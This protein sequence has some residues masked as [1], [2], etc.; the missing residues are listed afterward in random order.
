MGKM[1]KKKIH[2]LI[3]MLTMTALILGAG[4]F[5]L[6]ANDSSENATKIPVLA[7]HRFCTPEQFEK[8][9]NVRSLYMP[10]DKL[11]EQ[12]EFLRDFGY[13]TISAQEFEDWHNGKIKLPKKSVMITI[14]D[15]WYSSIKYALPI[16]DKYDIKSTVF[17]IGNRTEATTDT[18]EGEENKHSI[19]LDLIEKIQKEHPNFDIQSHGYDLHK[20]TPDAPI[21]KVSTFTYE[22]CFNDLRTQSE[23]FGFS[24]LAYPFGTYTDTLI[25]AIRDE[26]SIRIAFTY[27]DNGYATREQSPYEIKRIKISG[28]DGMEDFL[29]WFD[30]GEPVIKS[31]IADFCDD[32]YMYIDNTLTF[33]SAP[34]EKYS[35]MRK[36]GLGRWKEIGSVVADNK[37]ASFTDKN[38]RRNK[39][40]KY[41]VKRLLS[42]DGDTAEYTPYNKK[43]IKTVTK[44]VK[45]HVEYG[46]RTA[47]LTFRRNFFVD[48][49]KVFRKSSTTDYEFLV[50]KNQRKRLTIIYTDVFID[51]QDVDKIHSKLSFKHFIDPSRNDLVYAV[52][53]FR[54]YGDAIAMGPMLPDGEFNITDPNIVSVRKTS[55]TTASVRF[56]ICPNAKRYIIYSGVSNDQGEIAWNEVGDATGEGDGGTITTDVTI[57]K[58]DDCFAVKAEY[59]KNGETLYSGMEETYTT[60]YRNYKGTRMLVIGASAAYGCPYK[61]PYCRFVYSYP[62]RMAEMLGSEVDNMAIPGA[63]YSTAVEG[64]SSILTELVN[65]VEKGEEIRREAYHADVLNRNF[66][67]RTLADYDIFLVVA[68]GNDYNT[69]L[70]PG[71]VDSKDTATFAGSVN[72]VLDKLIKANEQRVAAGKK[73][74]AV[75]MV[76]TTYS[77]RKGN[78]RELHN[79]YETENRIGYTMKVYD[80][81]FKDIYKNYKSKGMNVLY[82]ET[83]DYL[84]ADNC[85]TATT[86]NL[87]MTRCTN[88]L[89]GAYLA[90]QF[91]ENNMLK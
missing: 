46:N 65:K 2:L 58:G 87:H 45:P 49:Y 13:T 11:E 78:F 19:G 29:K 68:G 15:G 74:I 42:G 16:F 14:D 30:E 39:R 59:E 81:V 86:D 55:P 50:D 3:C 35:I 32:S 44:Y 9:E 76:G 24:Y 36:F 51:T 66:E 34:G 26:A 7:Y 40:Y 21:G 61:K 88:G 47:V 91:A 79:R 90:K 70:E 28:T 43:G 22:E 83:E 89:F 17:L 25:N 12:M 27:G 80:D 41:T 60:K 33:K 63:T 23:L 75:V 8:V 6:A 57:A 10:T 5:A 38:I 4:V 31:L 64:R 20:Y 62:Y 73:G 37:E 18:S 82:I 1:F 54:N 84:N 77:N 67:H 71:T 52:R 69:S 85:S 48:G 72:V 56:G 53:P